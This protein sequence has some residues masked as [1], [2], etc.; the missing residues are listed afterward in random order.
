[1]FLRETLRPQ[2]VWLAELNGAPPRR[3]TNGSWTLEFVLPPG[4]SPSAL[5]WSSDG[6][7]LA[8]T[9][10]PA[11][12]SGKLDS[13]RVAL[14]DVATGAI[15]PLT[16]AR[17]FENNPVFAPRGNT[18]AYWYPRDG[19]GDLGWENEVWVVPADGGTP[20]SITRALDRNLFGARWMPDGK[21]LLV[22]GNDHTGVGAWIQPLDGPARRLD[23]G[24]LVIN[25][26][27]GYDIAVAAR[28]GTIAFTATTPDTPSELYVRPPSWAGCRPSRASSP[29]SMDGRATWRSGSTSG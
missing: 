2:H 9:Q 4:S 10:V 18:V 1:M 21:S 13:V 17:R 29:T 14:L 19:R 26:A 22:A 24:D 5:S 27:F 3:L 12:Q 25:G 6:R 11:P 7:T 15:S 16:S 28:A 8:L 23:T 20:R